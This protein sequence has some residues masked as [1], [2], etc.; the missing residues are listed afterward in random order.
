MLYGVECCPLK[1]NYRSKKWTIVVPMRM[2]ATE[3]NKGGRNED[4]KVSQNLKGK[5][6]IG[7]Q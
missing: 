3:S 2:L 4:K 5:S 7:Q 6:S 1:E